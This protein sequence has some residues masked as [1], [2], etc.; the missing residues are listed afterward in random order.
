MHFQAIMIA[1]APHVPTKKS[2]RGR[3]QS[4]PER[5]LDSVGTRVTQLRHALPNH[6]VETRLIRRGPPPTEEPV[7][8]DLAFKV[9]A[10]GV[11]LGAVILGIVLGVAHP[12]WV[13]AVVMLTGGLVLAAIVTLRSRPAHLIS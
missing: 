8:K 9:A 10:T 11:M 12:S 6:K 3:R 13:L 2:L 4:H 1:H 5:R 7:A